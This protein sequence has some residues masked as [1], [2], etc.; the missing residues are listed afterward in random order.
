MLLAAGIGCGGNGART[1]DAQPQAPQPSVQPTP[2][3]AIALPPGDAPARGTSAITE[4]QVRGVDTREVEGNLTPDVTV[5]TIAADPGGM[6]Y[7]VYELYGGAYAFDTIHFDISEVSDY[8]ALWLGVSD[9]GAQTWRWSQVESGDS[10][11][12]LSGF[13]ATGANGAAYLAV[14]LWDGGSARVNRLWIEVDTEV[15]FKEPVSLSGGVGLVNGMALMAGQWPCIAATRR[16]SDTEYHVKFYWSMEYLP[17]FVDWNVSSITEDFTGPPLALELVEDYEN[18]PAVA[19][20]T[21]GHSLWYTWADSQLP[22]G[23]AHWHWGRVGSTMDYGLGLAVMDGNPAVLY[24]AAGAVS[25]RRVV[26]ARGTGSQPVDFDWEYVDVAEN[27]DAAADYEG[28]SMAAIHGYRPAIQ[29]WDG[30]AHTHMFAV[31][32]APFPADPANMKSML[33]HDPPLGGVIS[34]TVDWQDS[35]ALFYDS[36]NSTDP[37]FARTEQPV[38]LATNEFQDHHVIIGRGAENFAACV[39]GDV[40][41]AAWRDTATGAVLCG[42]YDGDPEAGPTAGADWKVAVVDERETQ[43]EISI[44][45]LYY[46]IPGICYHVNA[47]GLFYFARPV[48][49]S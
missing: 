49:T 42:W 31:S 41:Y 46:G 22:D 13:T 19:L 33:V 30:V 29:Y 10:T 3:A 11:L 21:E 45:Q 25:G 8:E 40:I 38:P 20:V 44:V 39:I 5:L 47:D 9:Y 32:A 34:A 7:G 26:Y 6:A 43:G 16:I 12:D 36:I 18:H 48:P 4:W 15:W 35:A 17:S 23:M 37:R 2:L 14:V 27:T 28:L 24:E 1:A